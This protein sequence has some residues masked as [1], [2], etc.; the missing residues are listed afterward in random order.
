M[1]RLTVLDS[2]DEDAADSEPLNM[3][4]QTRSMD[5]PQPADNEEIDILDALITE[6]GLTLGPNG[7]LLSIGHAAEN[8]T[9]AVQR[10]Y[11]YEIETQF[12]LD[13]ASFKPMHRHKLCD[14]VGPENRENYDPPDALL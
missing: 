6:T 1:Q 11:E 7:R 3:G 2:E 8:I 5:S 14:P 13:P 4:R 12:G 10:L 9:G